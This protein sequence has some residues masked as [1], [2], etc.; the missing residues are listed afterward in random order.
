MNLDRM[1]EGRAEK[2]W[3]GVFHWSEVTINDI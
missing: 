1:S 3:L 2:G